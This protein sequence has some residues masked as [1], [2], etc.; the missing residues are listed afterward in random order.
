MLD[1]RLKSFA[2]PRQVEFIDAYNASGGSS[3]KAALILGVSGRTVRKQIARVKE[4]A[5]GAGFE[6][7]TGRIYPVPRGHIASGYSE[8]VK[9]G[10][11]DPLNRIVYWVKTNRR[12]T[13]QLSECRAVIEAMVEDL[14]K[15]PSSTYKGSVKDS[16]H[17]AVI[18]IGDPH[19][20]LRT[21]AREVGVDWDVKI[22]L[23][24][25]GKVF[26]RLFQRTPDTQEAII[27]NSGD[28]FHAD[29]I[30]GETERS[31]HKLDLDGRPAYWIDAGIQIMRGIIDMALEKYK[32]VVFVNTPGNHDDILGLTLGI[33]IKHIYSNES[34]L[35]CEIEPTP[36]QF[37]HRDK[38]L[39]GFCHGHTC[40]LAALPGKMA[41]D[42]SDLWG[43]TVYR[44]WFTGHVH[45]N[46]WVQFKEHPGCTVE[47]VGII[48]PRDAYA[49]GA[50]YGAK[51]GTQLCIFDRRGNMPDRYTE[52]VMPE[53]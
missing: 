48:P 10:P 45:H 7:D 26:A 17:F 16:N 49:Y 23:R 2:T 36:F 8:L 24:V 19:I 50:G 40:K 9:A 41:D 13:E 46:Q 5:A 37:I 30:R 43:Q 27:F 3:E 14:P 34:R 31:G 18:P 35:T 6:Y 51:R 4:R 32:R 44:H 42:R 52:T 39:L 33:A 38:V 12:I 29:N 20:G 22:A 53:D 15:L 21:W 25:F 28:F 11:D 1:E 47:S